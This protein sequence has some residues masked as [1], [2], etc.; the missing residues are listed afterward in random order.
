MIICTEK[1]NE[2]I[3]EI[4]PELGVPNPEK[5]LAPPMA[6]FF[7][8]GVHVLPEEAFDGITDECGEEVNLVIVNPKWEKAIIADWEMLERGLIKI[9]T[10]VRAKMIETGYNAETIT[11]N[12]TP[13]SN[14]D[15]IK[16]G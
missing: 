14:S 4:L 8:T 5:I 7:G 10:L 16:A 3:R 11:N 9:E 2:K 6:R 15:H 12:T 1:V 13:D